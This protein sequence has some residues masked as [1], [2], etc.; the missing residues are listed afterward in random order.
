[1]KL[2]NSMQNLKISNWFFGVFFNGMFLVFGQTQED[3][4][5]QKMLQFH[6]GFSPGGRHRNLQ[7]TYGSECCRPVD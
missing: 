2:T 1:M 4:A 5:H 3:Q 7:D 6:P